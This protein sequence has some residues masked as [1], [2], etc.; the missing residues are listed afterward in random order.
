MYY[1]IH[2]VLPMATKTINLRN[3]PEDLV[4]RAKAYAALQGLSLKEFILQAVRQV[5][6]AAG[7]ELGLTSRALFVAAKARRIAHTRQKKERK[8]DSRRA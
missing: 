3:V 5:L 2:M 7:P 4:R 6:D 1:M 8:R